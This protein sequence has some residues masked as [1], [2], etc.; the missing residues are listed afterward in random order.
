MKQ[1][2]WKI[3]ERNTF[4]HQTSKPVNL[5]NFIILFGNL[6]DNDLECLPQNSN[7]ETFKIQ[8]IKKV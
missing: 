1:K 6:K 5:Q 2:K 8:T 7:K 4:Q 3:F